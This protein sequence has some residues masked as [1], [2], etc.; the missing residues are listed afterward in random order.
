MENANHEACPNCNRSR[1]ESDEFK[2]QQSTNASSK[3]KKKKKETYKD[4]T[5]VPF[6]AKIAMTIYV[7]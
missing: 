2:G 5:M 6:K 3:K 7:F 4:P 1:L